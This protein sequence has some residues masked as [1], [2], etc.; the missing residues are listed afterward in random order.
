MKPWGS[1]YNEGMAQM[2]RTTVAELRGD[3]QYF[4]ELRFPGQ[5]PS[6][7]TRACVLF[8]S[9]GLW[10]LSAAR[11]GRWSR[12]WAPVRWPGRLLKRLLRIV[13]N[14]TNR[15][16]HVVTKCEVTSS[17][18]N[19][20]PGLYLSDLGHVHLGARSIGAGSIIH[21][22]VTI[23]RGKGSQDK[24]EIGRRVWIGPRCVIYG[25]IRIGDGATLLPDTVLTRNAPAGIVL[26]G[27]PATVVRR[28]FDNSALRAT[29]A[30]DEAFLRAAI[31]PG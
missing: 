19:L 28:N 31:G 15:F 7:W 11:L 23:G 5:K 26:Q 21:D 3:A 13:L 2:W 9:R 17:S 6:A 16:C 29:L 1:Y 27:N 25:S 4:H 14:L 18:W 10:V 8:G 24:A 12:L 20:E 22:H 30:T